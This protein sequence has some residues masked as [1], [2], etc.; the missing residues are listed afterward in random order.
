VTDTIHLGDIDN[1]LRVGAAVRQPLA[2][3]NLRGK[4]VTRENAYEV[5]QAG[6][7]TWYCLKFYQSPL[8]ESKNP[9]ATITVGGKVVIVCLG[10]TDGGSTT[11]R[12]LPVPG[13]PD[14]ARFG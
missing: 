13:H 4:T 1:I 7:W 3:K 10:S 9:I 11:G 14:A 2:T 5:W 8:A 12:T 6:S